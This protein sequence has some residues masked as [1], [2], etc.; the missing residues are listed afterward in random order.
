MNTY[1]SLTSIFDNQS[2]LL[3]TL[4][5][6]K[7]QTEIPTKCYI[8]LSEENYLLD[9]GFKNKIITNDN[10]K[11]YIETNSIFEIKWVRNIGSYRK[12]LPL[13]KEKWNE[14][15]IIITL[16][17]DTEYDSNLIYNLKK[18]YYNYNCVIN[19]RG[20][21]LKKQDNL[22][23]YENRD[24]LI[25]NY[26]YNFFTGKGGVL[27]HPSFFHKTDD[28]IF[29]EE[30]FSNLCNTTDDIW[31]NFI[32]ICNNINCFID[33]KKYMISDNT[34]KYGLYVNFNSKNKLNS[35]LNLNTFNMNETIKYLRKLNYNI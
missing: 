4:I 6:I 12:L 31:F 23:N 1:V 3:K 15:C 14:D 18:D 27:Y 17:D 13:L 34:T 26:L 21:T 20:F 8:Y 29:N 30:L 2:V 32:R 9:K 19:Y 33:N 22:F 11:K 5:S 7:N 24:N 10:L 35:K 28:L 16:D 25:N